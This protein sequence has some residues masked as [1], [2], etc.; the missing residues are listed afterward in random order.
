[1][2]RTVIDLFGLQITK[3]YDPIIDQDTDFVEIYDLCKKYTMTSRE[4]MYSLYQS[5]KYIV[6]NDISGDF[7]ECGVWKGGSSMLIAH[8]LK[9]LHVTDRKIYLY[10][11]FTGMVE[12]GCDDRKLFDPSIHATNIWRKKQKST[13]N[14]WCHSS[15]EETTK[16]MNSTGYGTENI[17][18]IVGDVT[19]TIPQNTPPKI[20]LLRLDTDWYTSTKHE[21][22]HLYPH[23]STNGILII[24]DYGDWL[25]AKKAVDEY[26]CKRSILLHR[27]DRSGRIHVKT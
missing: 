2:L 21:L 1:M 15:L 14:A 24:D 25:G 3:K 22:L 6:K 9:K 23:I 26:F 17:I 12:P 8:T 4:R 7:V 19:K 18:Y 13:Y 10:D 11:T 27:I 20:S 16:N 5:V